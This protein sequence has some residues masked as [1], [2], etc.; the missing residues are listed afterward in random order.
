[1]YEN[2]IVKKNAGVGTITLDRPKSLNALNKKMYR[3]L[4][5]ALTEMES[6]PNVRAILLTGSGERAF[7]AGADIKEAA[8]LASNS[9]TPP[10]DPPKIDPNWH[11][12]SCTKPT[13]GAINGLAYGG[14]AVIAS[15]LDIRVGCERTSFR[16]L[17]ASYGRINSTWSLPMQVGWPLAKELLFTARVIDAEE[18][19]KIGLLNRLVDSSEIMDE[20]NKIANQ[21]AANDPR[22]VQGMKEIMISNT[23]ESWEHMF[24]NEMEAM[25][26]TLKPTPVLEGFK[27]F[28]EKKEWK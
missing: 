4:D 19:L 20:A 25:S 22:M 3:E 15:A 24:K 14:A 28:L 8:R 7:S 12:A 18:A 6:D 5:S 16:F 10:P 13:I 17:A 21:I 9:D 26:G 27:D 1:M 2:I 23:G 11:I